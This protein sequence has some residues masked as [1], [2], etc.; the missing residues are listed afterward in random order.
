MG[1]VP[2]KN[3]KEEK[4][5]KNY[6]S[7][8]EIPAVNFQQ[9]VDF[10]NHIYGFEME[11][12]VNGNYAMAFF[13]A[14]NG[15]GGAIVAGPGSTPSDSGPLIYLNAG[16]DLNAIL[17]KVEEAGGRIVMS[18][19]LINKESGYFAIFIDSEGNKLALHS[20]N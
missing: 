15:I 11:K 8:F 1:G 14:K 19:T 13:P 4:P 5:I 9:A 10:Y 7:W 20:K 2:S 3:K 6:V 17:Q 12:N 16:N 18:K